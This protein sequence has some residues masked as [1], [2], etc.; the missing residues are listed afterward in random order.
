MSRGGCPT[1]GP[2]ASNTPVVVAIQSPLQDRNGR[3]AAPVPLADADRSRQTPACRRGP[4]GH[5]DRHSLGFS[6]SQYFATVFKRITGM[7]PR[8]P[9]RGRVARPQPS[10]Q[11]R[12]ALIRIEQRPVDGDRPARGQLSFSAG[13]VHESFP[14]PARQ[15]AVTH[16]SPAHGAIISRHT[17]RRKRWAWQVLLA[18]PCPC[19]SESL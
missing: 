15:T 9:L 6:S 17:I 3:F 2:G 12:P 14:Q 8:L 11:R 4:V 13:H 16:R 5:A 19:H 18:R 1:A 7:T 10:A